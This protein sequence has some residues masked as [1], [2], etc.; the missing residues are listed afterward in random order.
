MMKRTYRVSCAIAFAVL[1]V[2]PAIAAYSRDCPVTLEQVQEAVVQTA[3]M[4]DKAFYQSDT[5]EYLADLA[6]KID[7]NKIDQKTLGELETLL[8]S[9]NDLIRYWGAVALGNLGPRAK[10]AVPKLLKILAKVDCLNGP[11]T[12]ANGIR[13]A[14]KHIGVKAPP[15]PKCPQ[16]ISG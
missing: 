8:D 4:K 12:S 16:R 1:C 7:P 10:P 6:K 5:G 3:K 13:Y 2:M 14:L 15:P 9:D 11:I